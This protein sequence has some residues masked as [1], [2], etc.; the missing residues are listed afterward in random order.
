MHI[1]T[2]ATARGFGSCAI[3]DRRIAHSFR[4]LSLWIVILAAASASVLIASQANAQLSTARDKG[5]AWMMTHQRNDGS[6]VSTPGSEFVAT[7]TALDGFAN[8]GLKNF[9]YAQGI[10]WLAN[11]TAV[12]VD[13]LSRQMLALAQGKVNV[14][15]HFQK[16]LQKRNATLTWGAYQGFE[17][18]FPDTPLALSAIRVG[19][20]SY[21]DDEVKAAACLIVQSQKTGDSTIAGS[22][23]YIVPGSTPPASAIGSSILPTVYNILEI[24][25]I[26]TAKSWP[27][28]TCGSTQYTLQTAV[29][30]GISW[31]INQKKKS[32]G[33]FGQETA[34]TTFD[35]ALVYPVLSAL[36]PNDSAT[37]AALTYLINSQN[38][39]G[40]W[41]GDAL[42]TAFV[43][44]AI[45]A[46]TSGY[47]DTDKDGIP[48]S[49]ETI[50]GTNPNVADSRTLSTLSSNGNPLPADVTLLSNS[51]PQS[52]PIVGGS[53]TGSHSGDIN[54]DGVVDAADLAIGERIV[55]GLIVPTTA[56]VTR[57]DVAPPT[58]YNSVID[59]DDLAR[60]RRKILGL[61]EF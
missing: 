11:A 54:G 38:T 39:D 35:T 51:L 2:F 15:L 16:L 43:L 56:Q 33:G 20:L 17:T 44:K 57:G 14:A 52:Q 30:N 4:H 59:V 47:T 41:N 1:R 25:A 34:S 32:D 13:S 27:T 31:L 49:I 6:W 8:A 60:I 29:D 26:R 7:A 3:I 5:L 9:T 12:S 55:L 19:G 61:E 22:W 53:M 21:T 58:S 36:R 10:A 42:Q 45:P 28:I 18:S 23:S 48:D 50:L 46:L 24:E 40:S 37:S